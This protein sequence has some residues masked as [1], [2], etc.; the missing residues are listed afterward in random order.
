VRYVRKRVE[1]NTESER[2]RG[3]REKEK[4]RERGFFR[5]ILKCGSEVGTLD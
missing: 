1:E 3:K 5:Y 2:E 4:E